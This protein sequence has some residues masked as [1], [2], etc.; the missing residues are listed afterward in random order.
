M[1]LKKIRK[2]NKKKKKFSEKTKENDTKITKSDYIN[3]YRKTEKGK[4]HS[5]R[6]IQFRTG[7]CRTSQ[8]GTMRW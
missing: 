7:R 1:Q 8:F 4:N 2:F 6:K 3:M 5:R